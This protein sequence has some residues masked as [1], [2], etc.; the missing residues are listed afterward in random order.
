MKRREGGEKQDEGGKQAY[1]IG[2]KKTFKTMIRGVNNK[3]GL[4]MGAM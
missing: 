2:K 3:Q 4:K 1:G